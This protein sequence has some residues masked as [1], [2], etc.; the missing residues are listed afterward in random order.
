MWIASEYPKDCK[1]HIFI[2]SILLTSPG[3]RRQK[4]IYLFL[5]PVLS[6]LYFQVHHRLLFFPNINWNR[7][8]AA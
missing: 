3:V 5:Q 1:I 6:L 8:K 2:Y 4:K 7:P